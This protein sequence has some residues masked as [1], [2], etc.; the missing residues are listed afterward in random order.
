MLKISLLIKDKE[1]P[2]DVIR[3]DIEAQV[4]RSGLEMRLVVAPENRDHDSSQT[5]SS[6]LKAVARGHQW[7][8]WIAA[9]EIAGHRAIAQRV[10]LSER[11]VA[12]V[13]S[14]G[15]LAPVIVET[16]LDG[17]QPTHL[18]FNNLTRQVPINWNAQR[19][20]LGL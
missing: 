17:H 18:T 4:K 2:N 6:L 7:S 5:V 11:Y 3:L 13:L 20:A 12:R 8:E 19:H 16:I 15:Y 14:C 10:G 9:G 1:F